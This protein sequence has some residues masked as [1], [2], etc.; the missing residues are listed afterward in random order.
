MLFY[1]RCICPGEGLS[2]LGGS[3]AG[4][5]HPV[6]AQYQAQS[7]GGVLLLCRVHYLAFD[8]TL[9][10]SSLSEAS[11]WWKTPP[12]PWCH[13]GSPSRP[14]PLRLSGNLEPFHSAG[15]CQRDLF[16]QC[17]RQLEEF[18]S[19]LLFP[20]A[21]TAPLPQRGPQAAGPEAAE[22]R[23]RLHCHGFPAARPRGRA[24]PVGTCTNCSG[25][26]M[27]PHSFTWQ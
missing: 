25:S 10:P 12:F 26:K 8:R 4:R 15:G 23:S 11:R 17:P 7:L 14:F 3:G 20:N 22:S 16:S 2:G 13:G 5:D 18:I 6:P 1:P 21:V 19:H 9:S 24:V 27:A